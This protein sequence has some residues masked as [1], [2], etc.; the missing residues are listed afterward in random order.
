MSVGNNTYFVFSDEAGDYQ[1][2]RTDRFFTAHPFFIRAGVAIKAFDWPALR[3]N[4]NTIRKEIKLPDYCEAKWADICSIIAHRRRNENIPEGRSYSCLSNYS[5]EELICYVK[6]TLH[7]LTTCETP[8]AVF[9]VTDNSNVGAVA[10]DKMH[11][12]HIQDLMQRVE[13]ELQKY[14]GLG[15]MFLDSK[16]K[17][18][19]NIIRNAYS[20]IYLDGDFIRSYRHIVD[21]TAFVL[22]HQSFGIRLVDYYAGIFNNFLRGYNESSDLFRE[23]IWPILRKNPSGDP[24]GWGICVVPNNESIKLD[25]RKRLVS[26]HLIGESE[27]DNLF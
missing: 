4:Y 2:V 7:L 26:Y 16:D 12:M 24:M 3:D 5:N 21:S 8:F 25:F 9:T 14:N 18:I 10:V 1:E 17:T 27:R 13:F 19:D 15:V 6:K 23:E 11:K 20:S 22:S